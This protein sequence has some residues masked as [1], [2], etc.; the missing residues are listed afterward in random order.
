MLAKIGIVN[1]DGTV[2]LE[3]FVAPTMP[4]VDHREATTGIKASD[5]HGASGMT[6]QF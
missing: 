6:S 5:L 1:F 4:V 2:L 3:S